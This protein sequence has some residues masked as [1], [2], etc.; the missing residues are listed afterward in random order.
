MA[1]KKL[2]ELTELAA[3]PAN[4][5][6]VYIRD[7]SEEASAESKRIT[8]ANLAATA[9]AKITTHNNVANAHGAVSTATASKIVVRDASGRAAFAAPSANGDVAILST[10]TTHAGLTTAHGAVSAATASKMVVRDASARA[11]F[12]APATAGDVLIKGTKLTT[13]ELPNLT[14]TKIWQ[15]NGSNRP[16]E[17]S[18]PAAGAVFSGTEAEVYNGTAPTSWTNLDLSGTVGSNAALVLLKFHST[19]AT[20][21]H[22]AVRKNGDADEFYYT[23]TNCYG[24]ARGTEFETAYMVLLVAADSSG[25]IEWKCQSAR[26]GT[27]VDII[28]YI[29]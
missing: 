16:V 20:I 27:T 15:G 26:T 13:T 23:G 25:I 10:V 28:A 24:V 29:K 3:T 21:G 18:L 12:A 11:K 8:I 19:Q 4:E 1:D 9:D 14:N 5:D 2:S 7:V 6:E 17:V 22:I